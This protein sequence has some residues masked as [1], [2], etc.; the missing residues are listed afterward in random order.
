MPAPGS[1]QITVVIPCFNA[2][3]TLDACLRAVFDQTR[4]P[5]EVV[6]VNDASTDSSAT[7]ARSFPCTLVDMPVNRGVSAARNAG[8]AASDGTF[9]FFVDADVALYPDAIANALGPLAADP[10]LGVV[11]GIFAREAL[12]EDGP[13]EVYRVLHEHHW[14]ARNVGRVGATLFSLTAIPRSVF[15]AA[16]PFDESLRD[17]EDVEYG[18][19]LPAECGILMTDTVQGRHDEVDRMG[20]LLR[21][22]FRRAQM[23]VPIA[24]ARRWPAGGLR[25]LHRRSLVTSAL[26]VTTLP[27]GWLAPAALTLPLAMVLAFAC[28]DPAL[29]SF[30]RRERGARFLGYFLA[31]HFAV[32]VV[33][34]AGAVWGGVRWL[35][36]RRLAGTGQRVA[37][38]P[39]GAVPGADR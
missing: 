15:A 20:P 2:A 37:G 26:A 9:L 6:V 28:A 16:G 31:V 10:T 27:L 19:R 13:V 22:Q 8:V 38:P 33:V 4:R 17:G 39:V 21:E 18:S 25:A 5:D 32:H 23:L 1:G 24:M 30:V 11:Q 35:A 3:R 36:G 14:R 29:A 34:G 7:I 12:V